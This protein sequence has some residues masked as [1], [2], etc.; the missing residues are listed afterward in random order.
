[1][2]VIIDERE[3]LEYPFPNSIKLRLKTGDY[4]IEGYEQEIT[5]ERKSLEDYIKSLTSER[6]RF[7]AEWKRLQDFEFKAVVVEGSLEEIE[8]LDN[9]EN[10]LGSTASLIIDY[11]IPVIFAST[12]QLAF[13]ITERLLELFYRHKTEKKRTKNETRSGSSKGHCFED[14]L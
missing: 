9:F 6:N 5:V 10:I 3:K 4:S 1:M 2:K 14:Y 8:K 12:R 7:K 13:K 11:K